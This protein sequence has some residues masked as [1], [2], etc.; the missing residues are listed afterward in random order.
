MLLKGA[1]SINLPPGLKSLLNS[2]NALTGSAICSNTSEHNIVSTDAFSKGI[3][4][5]TK[6]NSYTI[7]YDGPEKST[8]QRIKDFVK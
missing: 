8:L 5:L 2:F 3:E 4:V 7:K 6:T 1:V